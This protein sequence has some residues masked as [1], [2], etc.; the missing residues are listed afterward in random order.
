MDPVPPGA[1][2]RCHYCH[3][4]LANPSHATAGGSDGQL[5]QAVE[6]AIADAVAQASALGPG[7]HVVRTT[8]T[9]KVTRQ[10][11]DPRDGAGT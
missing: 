7:R 5:G 8:V 9:T 11:V 4:A 2:A 10:V 6:Q 1:E 3:A